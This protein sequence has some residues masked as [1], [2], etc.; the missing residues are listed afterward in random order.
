MIIAIEGIDGAGKTT[1]ANFLKEEL[2]KRNFNV[3]A[4]KEPTN[5]KWGMK[6]QKLLDNRDAT[7]EKEFELFLKDREFDVKKNIMPAIKEGK[8]I[9]MDRY[10]Y[11]MA[12]YQG[13]LGINRE[14]I[15][16]ENEK[17]APKP[18]LVIILDI[19][20]RTSLERIK[21]RSS[22]QDSFENL[23]YLEEV[24]KAFLSYKNEKRV[25]IINSEKDL[26]YVKNKVIHI[27]LKFLLNFK[28]YNSS[29]K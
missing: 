17:I 21:K 7:P 22:K 8:I 23:N 16:K 2:D 26:D 11:S 27:V 3:V 10:Y 12:P 13:A 20:P 14:I 28:E 5:S 29:N 4:F 1:I 25:V 18:N 9:I 6:I 24:R 19:N 15:K